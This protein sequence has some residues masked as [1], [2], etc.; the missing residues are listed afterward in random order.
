MVGAGS[1]L[2]IIDG[3]KSLHTVK[4]NP[5]INEWLERADPLAVRHTALR[6]S[7]D[8]EAFIRAG[9]PAGWIESSGT[10]QSW[11]AYH[12]LQ[13]E[14]A[15][16]DPRMLERAATLLFRVAQHLERGKCG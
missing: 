3:V 10:K 12:T 1:D 8:F 5:Q 6:R 7:S 13:D 2:R 4:T 9:I 14:L 16:I 11:Q 15:L